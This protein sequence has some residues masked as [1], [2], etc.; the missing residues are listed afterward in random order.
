MGKVKKHVM[1]MLKN[2]GVF[3]MTWKIKVIIL[4]IVFLSISGCIESETQNPPKGLGGNVIQYRANNYDD[5]VTA[6]CDDRVICYNVDDGYG[7]SGSCFRDADLV[8]KYCG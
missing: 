3:E 8:E 6:F 7:S 5:Y 2:H 1:V 4:L